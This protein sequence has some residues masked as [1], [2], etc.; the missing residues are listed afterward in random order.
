MQKFDLSIWLQDKSR[1]VVTRDG[2]PVRIICWDKKDIE[3]PIVGLVSNENGLKEKEGCCSFAINGKAWGDACYDLFF[4]DKEEELTEFEKA[5]KQVMWTAY[6]YD[7]CSNGK[8]V[9]DISN[10]KATSKTLLDLAR[11]EILKDS[12]KWKNINQIQVQNH[13]AHIANGII[14]P[15]GYFISYYD[16]ETLPKEE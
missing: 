1:K 5:V 13:Y 6:N 15:S 14:N 4:A 11:K 8:D 2:R 7:D 16:L 10:V 12:P 3:Y 9:D